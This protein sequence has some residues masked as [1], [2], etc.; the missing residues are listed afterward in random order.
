MG[1]TLADLSESERWRLM[2]SAAKSGMAAQGYSLARV[3]GRGKSNVWH[4]TKDGET[5][6]VSIRTTRV[7]YI[8]FPP[9][10]RGTKW[11]TLDDVELVAVAAVDSKDAPENIVVY[12][13]PAA[14]LRQRF[15]ASYA[16]RVKDGQSIKDNFGMWVELDRDDRGIPASVGTGIIE[17]YN[18]IGVYAIADL[19]PK[20]SK[21]EAN[22]EKPG[23]AVDEI[24]APPRL[25]TIAEVMAWA[26]NRVAQIVGVRAEAVKLDLKVE[27]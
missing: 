19:L 11:K 1:K 22:D 2:V 14:D 16:A 7:R 4:V 5:R 6:M 10:E 25:A 3:P 23:Q 27:Y 13:F 8:A 17:H 20:H 21:V 9:L 18:P 26:R 24:P 12:L 15:H